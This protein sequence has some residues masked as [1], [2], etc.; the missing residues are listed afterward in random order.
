MAAVRGVDFNIIM[1]DGVRRVETKDT[2]SLE[3]LVLDDLF[4]HGLSVVKEFPSLF[5]HC[6]IIK[7]LRVCAIR[8]LA[9][10]L[11]ALE[12]RVPIDVRYEFLKI[13]LNE[14]LCPQ[15]RGLNDGD[16]VPVS[17]L[18]PLVPGLSE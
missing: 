7:D 13:I 5:T 6:L 8:V 16:L 3:P 18:H 15:E 12:E 17:D 14:Y 9:S 1:L 11:P 2:S 10:D 4:Q